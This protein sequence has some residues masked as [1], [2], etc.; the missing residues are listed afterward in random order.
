ME[1]APTQETARPSALDELAA[2]PSSR[3]RF[4]KTLGT[5][6][7]AGL[8]AAVLAACG[9]KETP[10]TPGG[11]NA[12]TGAGVGTDKY[13]KGDVG[14]VGY[15]LTVEYLEDAFYV[16]ANDSGQLKG[17]AAD[18]ARTFGQQEKEHIKALEKAARDLG[19]EPPARPEAVFPLDGPRV[20]VEAGLGIESLGAAGMLAQLSRI[21]DKELLAAVL[22]IHSVEGRHVAALAEVLG[23][24]PAPQGAFSQPVQAGDVLSQLHRL[25]TGGTV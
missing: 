14:I 23:E 22:A 9:E 18:L 25:T 8:F 10:T 19:G 12:N 16:A 2:D 20:I 21:E 6:G 24:D 4:L 13:G 11:S 7:A 15:A 17:R 1:T 5:T 3:G